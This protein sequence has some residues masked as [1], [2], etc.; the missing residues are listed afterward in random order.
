MANFFDLVKA[1]LPEDVSLQEILPL[2]PKAWW[3]EKPYIA[4]AHALRKCP[5]INWDAYLAQNPDV[6]S[7]GMDPCLHF[8]RH[9]IYEGR[10][11]ASWHPLRQPEMPDTPL[12]SIVLINFNNAH[13][14]DKCIG[15][16]LGQTLPNIELIAVDDCSTDNSLAIIRGYAAQDKRVKVLVNERNSATLITRKAGV[17]AATGRY[18]MFLDS[19]DYLAPNACE[20]AVQ[21][22][23]Q[24]YDMVKFGAEIIN[25]LNAPRAAIEDANDFCNRGETGEYFN[26][27]IIT[28]IFRDGKIS[29][30]VWSF[31]Y[32]REIAAA[33]FAELPAEYATGP[34]DLYGLLAIARHARS[35]LKIEARLLFYNFGPGVS[36]TYDKPKVLKY[37]PAIC[38]T[39]CAVRRYA[40]KYSLNIGINNLYRNLCADLLERLLPAGSDADVADCFRELTEKLGFPAILE[41]LLE[42]HDKQQERIAA[43][44]QPLANTLPAREIRHIGFFFPRLHYGGA[45]SMIISLCKLL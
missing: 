30:H 19:D 33:A 25:S 29:W 5:R 38:N 9:G 36:A 16:V 14:L 24:G 4:S 8:L 15:S 28:T 39:I 34:D 35:L 18:L 43:L 7:A 41:A 42:R 31:I 45:E 27:Q 11:L 13:L 10:K 23:S 6:K 37:A 12:V 26:D 2:S 1:T 22:I 32:L 44:I 40:D 3:Q 17:A 21:V 20:T